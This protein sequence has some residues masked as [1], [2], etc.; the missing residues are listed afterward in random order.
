MKEE[1]K[2]TTKKNTTKKQGV[3]NSST[4]K[5]STTKKNTAAKKTTVSKKTTTTKKSTTTKTNP[6]KKSTTTKSNVQK[7][8]KPV[9]K[10]VKVNFE[11][12][13]TKVQENVEFP[14]N[15]FSQEELKDTQKTIIFTVPEKENIN[16]VVKEL[17]E[18]KENEKVEK[19]LIRSTA[20]KNA[21]IV[22]AVLMVAI[23][24]LTVGYIIKD[25]KKDSI[26][27]A[28]LNNNVYDKI[29]ENSKERDERLK[30][31]KDD[32]QQ[33]VIEDYSNIRTI[34]L[35]EFE[36]K[37]LNHES[38]VVLISKTTC[39]YCN[40]Y[41]PIINEEL[42]IQEKNIYRINVQN[43][44]KDEVKILMEYY[45]FNLTPTIFYVDE[46]GI[47]ADELIGIQEKDVFSEWMS[48][49]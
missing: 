33:E 43:M 17:K 5:T 48:N 9:E 16:E 37:V 3:K 26:K 47:V 45:T 31:K 29:I 42:N 36:E 11:P 32:E 19:E 14:E 22:I 30:N 24:A 15:K 41:E 35:E 38:M 21:I 10:E 25:N 7:K 6:A 39:Y 18:N 4:K 49:K 2:V 40:I 34:T 28:T 44:K 12:R 13:E 20:K 23:V 1:K 8:T 46:N 27:P